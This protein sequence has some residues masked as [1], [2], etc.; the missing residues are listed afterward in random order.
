M[1]GNVPPDSLALSHTPQAIRARLERAKH[2]SLVRDAIL[3]A[4]DGCVTTFAVVAG[5]IG[6]ELSDRVVIIL[7]FANLLADGFSMAASNYL[8]AKSLNE[9]LDKA[10]AEELEHIER[11]PEGEREEIRQIF[12]SKGF[13]GDLLEKVVSVIAGNRKTWVDTMI[14]EEVGLR[15]GDA[16]P[17]RAA[18]ATFGAF[19][20]AGMVPLL[21]FLLPWFGTQASFP[22]SCLATAAAFFLVGAI[23][24]R[25][26]GQ[27][28]WKS[29]G[30]TLL[31]G[32]AAASLAYGVGLGLSGLVPR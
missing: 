16:K 23:K 7:G 26:V 8:G 20:L 15:L 32:G 2:P 30:A 12:A 19:C 11:I 13:E 31:L 4:T 24:G 29:G 22:A 21:P 14:T 5:A 18:W 9:E 17:R 28:P 10:I 1:A 25:V 6:G 3:G 27:V